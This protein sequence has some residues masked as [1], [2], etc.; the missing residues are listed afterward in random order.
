MSVLDWLSGKKT[1][2]IAAAMVI[3]AGLHAEGYISDS[4]FETLRTSSWVGAWPPSG[5]V[6]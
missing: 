4:L 6:C 3:L 2:L 5:R 1:Y